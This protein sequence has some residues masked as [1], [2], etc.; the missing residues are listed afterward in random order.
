MN[1]FWYSAI[2]CL[3]VMA[4]STP[5]EQAVDHA[6]FE[7]LRAYRQTNGL[8]TDY[9][10]ASH[11]LNNCAISQLDY[12]VA[13]KQ[14]THF[15]ADRAEMADVNKR[16]DWFAAQVEGDLQKEGLNLGRHAL[17]RENLCV[18]KLY[19]ETHNRPERIA[20]FLLGEYLS[21]TRYR[22][23]LAS[24]RLVAVSS[25]TRLDEAN[26]KVYHIAVFYYDRSPQKLEARVE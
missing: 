5:V 25:Q 13:T 3:H 20:E 12:V 23:N 2:L 1:F 24:D 16:F 9:Q 18:M 10:E 19:P 4:F 8:N 17:I 15:Q 14:F 11:L 22:Q 7:R 26:K 6:F 21:T